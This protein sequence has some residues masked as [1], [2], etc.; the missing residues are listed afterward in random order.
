MTLKKD[1][2][3]V[4]FKMLTECNGRDQ[5]GTYKSSTCNLIKQS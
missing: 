1:V 4:S 5:G 3:C 2:D